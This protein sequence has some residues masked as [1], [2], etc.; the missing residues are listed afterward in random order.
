MADKQKHYQRHAKSAERQSGGCSAMHISLKIHKKESLMIRFFFFLH[1]NWKSKLL[2]DTKV[3]PLPCSRVITAPSFCQVKL[4]SKA[5]YCTV[6]PV[7]IRPPRYT[8]I[9]KPSATYLVLLLRCMQ[10]SGLHGFWRRKSLL[11]LSLLLASLSGLHDVSP[12]WNKGW[13]FIYAGL[14][15]LSWW[16]YRMCVCLFVCV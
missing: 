7:R 10:S 15:S 9:A 16:A 4:I 2:Q 12:S 11:P 1:N 8:H 13:A 5:S 14:L 3:S 6:A